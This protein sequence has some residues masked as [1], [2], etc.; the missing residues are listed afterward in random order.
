MSRRFSP[1]RQTQRQA[2]GTCAQVRCWIVGFRDARHHDN[3]EVLG[4]KAF[5]DSGQIEHRGIQAIAC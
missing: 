1:A 4:D 2:R 3:F 5:E